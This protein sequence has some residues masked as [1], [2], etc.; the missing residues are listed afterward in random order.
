MTYSIWVYLNFN[1]KDQIVAKH[2][3]NLSQ[4]FVNINK[5][6]SS[7]T[8]EVIHNNQSLSHENKDFTTHSSSIQNLVGIIQ[9]N[10]S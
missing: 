5:H 8:T 1:V 6:V 4:R 3:L 2:N 7:V 10:E 9:S